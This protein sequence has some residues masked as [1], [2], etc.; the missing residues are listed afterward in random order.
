[1]SRAAEATGASQP[2]L[3]RQIAALEA[4]IGA[5]LFTRGARGSL[6]TEAGRALVGPARQMQAAAHSLQLAAKGQSQSLSG[7]VRIS[8][9]EIMCVHFLPPMLLSLRDAHPEIQIDLLANN[10]LDN[11]LE[12][13]AD[14]ALRMLRPAQDNLLA[15]H[16]GDMAMG[17]YATQ[18]YL[19]R[20]G[21]EFSL[22]TMSAFDW[23]GYDKSELI[24]RGTR[25]LGL[26]M[27]RESFGMRCDNEIVCWQALLDG[28][29]IGFGLDLLAV[30]YPELVRVFP[31]E[32]I[33]GI[34]LWLT[35][36]LELRSNP[37]IR[38]VFDHLAKH[39]GLLLHRSA[40]AASSS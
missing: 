34:P 12:R 3:S 7:T 1:V 27:T 18:A 38:A 21:L 29:G 17:A 33:P 6:L 39:F 14:I 16:L 10:A 26:P 5:A 22:H 9:S 23:I 24:L 40:E 31:A 13:K 35:A 32:W 30:R 2:T 11:L 8:A 37:R 20:K 15:R 28:L 4:A 36:P 19:A 25:A